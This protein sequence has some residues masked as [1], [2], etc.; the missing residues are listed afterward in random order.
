MEKMTDVRS[1]SAKRK[2]S[3]EWLV[4]GI[5]RCLTNKATVNRMAVKC[6]DSIQI[7]VARFVLHEK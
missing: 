4:K 2:W 6:T 7:I 5:N 3:K 1:V